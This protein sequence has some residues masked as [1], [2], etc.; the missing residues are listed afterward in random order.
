M[1]GGGHPPQRVL[2]CTVI[3]PHTCRRAAAAMPP[4]SYRNCGR[5][6]F[7]CLSVR[8]PCPGVRARTAVAGLLLL[9][10]LVLLLPA[11]SRQWRRPAAGA[12]DGGAL[13]HLLDPL[14]A[15]VVG[16][17]GSIPAAGTSR[18]PPTSTASPAPAIK[19]TGAGRSPQQT[20][21]AAAGTARRPFARPRRP[22]PERTVAVYVR[23]AA[24]EVCVCDAAVPRCAG[25]LCRTPAE[26]GLPPGHPQAR[27]CDPCA[28]GLAVHR[29]CMHTIQ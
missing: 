3:W 23:A 24:A 22:C 10:P 4:I 1:H 26:I 9:L 5:G 8:H 27:R 2:A 16:L 14:T 12:R 17:D 19:A 25:G 18:R 6:W 28:P 7:G 13:L 20:A 11:A 15:G 29:T 21:A